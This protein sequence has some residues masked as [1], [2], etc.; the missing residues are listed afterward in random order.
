MVPL[1]QAAV[2]RRPTQELRWLILK[3]RPP[4][5]RE[6]V[7]RLPC[8]AH[9]PVYSMASKGFDAHAGAARADDPL[10]A[11]DVDVHEEGVVIEEYL[12]QLQ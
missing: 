3:R 12:K 5:P 10:A 7:V 4:L 1:F 9:L 6:S 8:T 2:L 11:Y